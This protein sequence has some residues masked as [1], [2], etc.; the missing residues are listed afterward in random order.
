MLIEQFVLSIF[1]QNTRVVA[2]SATKQAICIDPAEPSPAVAD[3]ITAKGLDLKAITLT[4]GHLDHIGGVAFLHERF[5]DAEILL[6]K[7]D[8]D[9]YYGLPS[10]PLFMGMQPQQLAA[11]GLQ[12][13][14]PPALTRNWED[15]EIFQVGE[16][17]FEVRHCPGHTPGHVVLVASSAKKVFVG[18]CLFEGSIGR[19]DLPGGDHAQLLDSIGRNLLTLDDDFIVYSGHGRE[20]TIGRERMSN[21]FLNGLYDLSRRGRFV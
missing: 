1:Q 4:H 15:G 11:L 3:L 18:D 13:K 6:H 16:L 14:E 8:E 9:L 20:T 10:Q 7:G 5:P 21:P 12:Y 2:C 17:E 19:T